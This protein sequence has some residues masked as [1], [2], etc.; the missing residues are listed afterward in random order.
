[1][2]ILSISIAKTHRPVGQKPYG[3]FHHF[4]ALAQDKS[5]K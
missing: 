3:T 2:T 1:M 4:V 5:I